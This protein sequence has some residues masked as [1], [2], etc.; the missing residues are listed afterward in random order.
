MK[1][2]NIE[3]IALK[4]INY[5]D[6]DKVYT[7]F[8]KE[9]GKL[10]V[11]AKGVRKISSKRGG[12]LDTL[13]H[14]VLNVSDNNGYLYVN[15]VK[16][17]K[18]FSKLKAKYEHVIK[19]YYLLELISTFTVEGEEYRKIFDL[20]TKTLNVLNS[21]NVELVSLAISY[22]ELNLIKELGYDITLNKCVNCSKEF[23]LAWEYCFFNFSLGGFMCPDC[24]RNLGFKLDILDAQYLNLLSK[25]R[26][27]D[28]E[29]IPNKS[30]DVLK[31]HIKSIL[32]KD[33][34]VINIFGH[35]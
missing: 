22:F 13:N 28:K 4:N 15:E 2:L 23:S 18:S 9:Q 6:S 30:F 5:K 3:C 29:Y 21:S 19:A 10:T 35:I 24:G 11:F 1:R 32:D 25:G 20:L 33:L 8:S 17:K 7:V 27:Q 16:L 34:K 12:Q 31:I 26:V 14:V